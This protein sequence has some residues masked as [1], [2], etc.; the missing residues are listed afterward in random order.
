MRKTLAEEFTDIYIY[1]LRGNQRTFGEQSRK[2]GGKVFGGGSRATVAITILVRNTTKTGPAR[3]HY[4][5][6]GDYLTR[7]Q[8]LDIVAKAKSVNGLEI[9]DITPNTHGD[10]LNQRR[11]D[12]DKFL[13]LTPSAEGSVFSWTGPGSQ[14]NRDPWATNFSTQQV[15]NSME[16]AVDTY[17][18]DRALGKAVVTTDETK[19]KWTRSLI[20]RLERGD[21]L[22]GELAPVGVTAY[23]PYEK[24]RWYSDLR[25][26]HNVGVARRYRPKQG[27]ENYG[28]AFTGLGTAAAFAVLMVKDIPDVQ[29]L[30]NMGFAARWRYDPADSGS[31]LDIAG[32][33]DVIDGYRKVDNIDRTASKI[34]ESAYGSGFLN[35]DIFHYAYG[36]LHSPEYRE[37]YAA[38]LKRIPPRV[39]IVNDPWPFVEAGQELSELH[40]GYEEVEPYPL[41]GLDLTASGDPYR[42]YRVEKMQFAKTRDPA[43]K[44][45]V[46]D[47][48]SIIY[49]SNVTL[50]DIPEAAYR[51]VLGTRSAIEWIVDRYQTRIDK[52]SGIANDPN[53]WSREVGEPRYILDLLARVVTVSLETMRIVD[54]LPALAVRSE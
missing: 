37:A 2:E 13:S 33:C 43:T 30:S 10:W 1:N 28:F 17:E 45:L 38:D 27:L 32:D 40:L 16:I 22:A 51:Y 20:Q 36:I 48:N 50:T 23:R 49:N 52:D 42:F 18:H 5:D 26:M 9:V 34:F 19:I 8:K 29:L 4:K 11:D 46:T 41:T 7:E 6:I 15:L 21:S 47:Q 54:A 24:R 25:W 14:S 3:I 35:T 12:F 39:P 31:M 44:K 53:E